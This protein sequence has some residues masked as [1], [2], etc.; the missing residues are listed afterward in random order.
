MTEMDGWERLERIKAI[1]QTPW[2]LKEKIEAIS[3]QLN[4]PIGKLYCIW[5]V[6]EMEKKD[7]FTELVSRE[8]Q[9]LWDE[10]P[11]GPCNEHS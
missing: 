2:S 9:H 7:F 3:R 5:Y 11:G 10:L 6:C 1:A 8:L 4:L